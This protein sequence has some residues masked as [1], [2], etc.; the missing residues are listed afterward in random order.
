VDSADSWM[1]LHIAYLSLL[2]DKRVEVRNMF[3][4]PIIFQATLRRPV[5]AIPFRLSARHLDYA[6]FSNST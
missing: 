2:K 4:G 6:A 3:C 5:A 1:F